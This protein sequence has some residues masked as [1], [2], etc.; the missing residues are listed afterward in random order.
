MNPKH[1][2]PLY[3]YV[4]VWSRDDGRLSLYRIL[5]IIG[6]GY[7]VQSRDY[8]DAD[9]K[10][11]QM[12]HLDQQFIELLSEEPPERRMSPEP[13]IQQ[14]VAAFDKEFQDGA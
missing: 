7:V 3:R 9:L 6:I 11:E 13:S 4:P 1:S 5:E 14:A 10:Q 12:R 2:R 8:V